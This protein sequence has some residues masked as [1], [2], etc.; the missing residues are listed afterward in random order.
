MA[1]LYIRGPVG[2]ATAVA[3]IAVFSIIAVAGPDCCARQAD[4]VMPSDCSHRSDQTQPA[5]SC[6]CI[7]YMA[8]AAAVVPPIVALRETAPIHPQEFTCSMEVAR[9]ALAALNNSSTLLK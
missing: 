3:L 5:Q 9:F 7:A 1:Q 4:P 2:T 6:N 8:N